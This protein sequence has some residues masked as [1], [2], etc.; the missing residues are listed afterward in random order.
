MEDVGQFGRSLVTGGTLGADGSGIELNVK[1]DDFSN[2]VISDFTLTDVGLSSGGGEPHENGAAIAIKARD[3]GAYSA[4]PATLDAV[5]IE[6]GTIDGTSTGVRIG[7]PG[8]TNVGPTN[9]Q[10]SNVTITDSVIGDYDNRSQSSLD[11]ELSDGNDNVSTNP[12]ATGPIHYAGLGGDDTYTILATDTVTEN[13]G[14]GID[15]VRTQSSHTLADNVENLTLLDGASNSED[16]EDFSLGPIAD[17]ENDWVFRGGTIDQAVEVDPADPGNQVF[18]MSSDPSTGA[19]AGPYTP[20][21]PSTAGEPSTTADYD[22]MQIT[23]DIK[24]VQPYDNSRLEIDFGTDA[25]NDRNN[26]MVIENIEGEGLRIAVA[27]PLLDGNWDTGNNTINDFSAFTGNR[28]LVEGL[29]PT[30]EYQITMVV[31]FVDGQ[32][33]D[34]VDFYLNGEY[35]GSSTTFENF[36]DALGGTHADNAEA[37]QVSNLMFRGSAGGGLTPATQDGPGGEN[38]GFYVDNIVY[39]VFDQDGP[40]GTGNDAANVITGNSGNNTL[41]GLGGDDTLNGG[42]GDDTLIGG[43]G[44]DMIDGGIGND[45]A[46]FSGNFFD[47][48]FVQIDANTLSVVD[49]R[50]GSPDGTDT[51]VNVEQLVFADIPG[52]I[53]PADALAQ[54]Q[55]PPVV[56]GPVTLAAIGEDSGA[57]LITQAELLANASDANGDTLTASNLAIASGLGS[58]VDNGNGTWTY[59]P[60]ANDSSSVTFSYQISDG[61][62][63]PVATT[64]VLDITPVSDPPV[65]SVADHSLA[66][67]AWAKLDD[68]LTY[69]DADGDPAVLYQFYDAGTASTSAFIAN[70]AVVP[71]GTVATIAAGD[72]DE[73]WIGGAH[74]GGSETFYVRAYDGTSWGAWDSFTVTTTGSTGPGPAS[75][76]LAWYFGNVWEGTNGLGWEYGWHLTS[77]W[78]YGWYYDFGDTGWDFGWTWNPFSGWERSWYWK[79]GWEYGWHHTSGWAY[80]AHYDHSA[81][82]LAWV[83]TGGWWYVGGFYEYLGWGWEFGW[84]QQGGW[85]FG[86]HYNHN[87]AGWHY[88]WTWNTS[89]GWNLGWY[90]NSGWELGWYTTGSWA[91][92]WH[93]DYAN[94][95][96]GALWAT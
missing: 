23:F 56:S 33:N 39:S 9:V 1:Y 5:T 46:T 67:Y 80:G 10:V 70:G 49:N 27:D 91:Y 58:L 52:G 18:R 71:A 36:W 66:P 42:I 12:A 8:K 32:D 51:I 69:T 75:N 19:F 93:Y 83:Q 26:F 13:P 73:Y 59:T 72:I 82:S 17:G 20:A 47:Y 79:T 84:Y 34:T 96:W 48:S 90:Y 57:R 95:N 35:I 81:W 38:Q 37:K 77:G 21:L 44:N 22:S 31:H 62:T 41:S 2:V 40:D 4:D 7:E 85:A 11:V 24:A 88:G 3:D 64:A 54:Q 92:G 60:A 6:D 76:P 30:Q 50:A 89:S 61:F 87:T 45:A 28:T 86:W 94:Y 74:V 14:E 43:A 65:V 15:E 55:V 63:A 25:Q 53:T 78:A 29:D 16:F 68:W